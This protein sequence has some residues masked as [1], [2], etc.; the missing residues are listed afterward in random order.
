MTLNK[1]NCNSNPKPVQDE[2]PKK[3]DSA[4]IIQQET[5]AHE[6]TELKDIASDFVPLESLKLLSNFNQKILLIF[7]PR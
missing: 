2:P 1:E 3:E 7:S 6:T 5:A 4:E